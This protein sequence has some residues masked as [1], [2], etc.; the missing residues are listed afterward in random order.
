ME[1][2]PQMVDKIHCHRVFYGRR[3]NQKTIPR[4]NGDLLT[5]TMGE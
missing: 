1:L 3:K 4:E 2:H 5:G